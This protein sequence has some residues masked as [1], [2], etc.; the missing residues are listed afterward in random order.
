MMIFAL[1]MSRR[2]LYYVAAL[3]WG[4][5]GMII[6][7]KGIRAYTQMDP[8][9]LWWLLLITVFVLTGFYFMFTKI[10]NKYCARLAALPQKASLLQT[11]PLRGWVLIVFMS[12]L[13]MALKFLGVPAAF[14]AS[15]YSGLGPML[16]LAAVR[17]CARA[18]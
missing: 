6:T 8:E 3:L 18:E 15:F 17:F 5:P 4:D 14:T 12:C 9:N 13:G 1:A 10:V 7:N 16:V 2:T 11:F